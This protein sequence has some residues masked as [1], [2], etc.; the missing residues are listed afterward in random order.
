MFITYPST[1]NQIKMIAVIMFLFIL[2]SN[3]LVH[4]QEILHTVVEGGQVEDNNNEAA[5]GLLFSRT[6]SSG[7]VSNTASGVVGSFVND[8]YDTTSAGGSNDDYAIAS[9][10]HNAA[11]DSIQRKLDNNDSGDRAFIGRGTNNVATG[12]NSVV[13][14][15]SYNEATGDF[16]PFLVVVEMLLL[17]V[18]QLSEVVLTM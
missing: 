14:G 8:G 16:L 10:L 15:G 11:S 7:D 1:L 17:K 18:P 13:V 2:S 6:I 5:T 4:G 3:P 12:A 9:G